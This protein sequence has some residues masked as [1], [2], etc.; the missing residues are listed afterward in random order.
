MAVHYNF[1]DLFELAVV[2]VP[3]RTAIIDGS[4]QY[5]LTGRL[6]P[7]L[8]YDSTWE[9]WFPKAFQDLRFLSFVEGAGH[10]LQVEKP[11]ETTAQMLRRLMPVVSGMRRAGALRLT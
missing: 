10:W 6:D 7:V 2:K 3:N 4:R 1:A 8:D 11:A 9:S 5:E